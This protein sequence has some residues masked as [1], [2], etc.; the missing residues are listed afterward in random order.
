MSRQCINESEAEEDGF[1]PLG[2]DRLDNDG[3]YEDDNVVPCCTVRNFT[4][5]NL[6]VDDFYQACEN[7]VAFVDLGISATIHVPWKNNGNEITTARTYEASVHG[8]SLS[9][10]LRINLFFLCHKVALKT[11]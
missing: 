3:I 11:Q 2:P 9:R 10:L 6:A 1:R 7:V 5:R 8:T 4:R